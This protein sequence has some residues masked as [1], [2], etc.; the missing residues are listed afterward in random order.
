MEYE[1]F[2]PRKLHSGE[3]LDV[4]LAELWWLASLFGKVT[5]EGLACAFMA[6]HPENVH[7]LLRAGSQMETLDLGQIL[8]RA[9]AVI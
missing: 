9:R 1:Q 3:S 4:F 7:Q 8:V 5:D 2:V 6:G